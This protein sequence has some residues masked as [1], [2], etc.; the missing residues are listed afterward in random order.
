MNVVKVR[1]FAL[2]IIV[3]TGNFQFLFSRYYCFHAEEILK[4]YTWP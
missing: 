3:Y 2:K 4:F 1:K